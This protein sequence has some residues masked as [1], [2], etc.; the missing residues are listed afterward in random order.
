[1]GGKT[2]HCGKPFAGG[3]VVAAY[4]TEFFG[5]FVYS[6]E[7]S[8]EELLRREESFKLAVRDSLSGSEAEFIHFEADG[9]GLR[10]QCALKDD[11]ENVFQ[12]ICA[13]IAP[14]VRNGIDGRLL[15]VNKNLHALHAYSLYAGE[16]QEAV[17]VMPPP[18]RL[19]AHRPPLVS[20]Q[21]RPAPKKRVAARKDTG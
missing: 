13:G 11:N 4:Q 16:W 19:E 1:L 14:H 15:F 12:E 2:G 10:V 9:D 5:Y 8:Y 21:P 6:P 3:V 7:L 17:I 18:G 20:N